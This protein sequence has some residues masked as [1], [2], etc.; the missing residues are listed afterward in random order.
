MLLLQCSLC[1]LLNLFAFVCFLDSLV[2]DCTSGV[3]E[4]LLRGGDILDA[5]LGRECPLVLRCQRPVSI[6]GALVLAGRLLA[7]LPLRVL[8]EQRRDLDVLSESCSF[9]LGHRIVRS[10]WKVTLLGVEVEIVGLAEGQLLRLLPAPIN[11]I[12]TSIPHLVSASPNVDYHFFVLDSTSL[13]GLRRRVDVVRDRMLVLTL[14]RV[15]VLLHVCRNALR[16]RCHRAFRL[17]GLAAS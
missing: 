8:V 14:V 16:L 9:S 3:L 13:R 1:V 2:I 6:E 17:S 5:E 7:P 15:N 10:S 12:F 11:F 4:V